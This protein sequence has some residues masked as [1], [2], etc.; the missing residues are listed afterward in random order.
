VPI[1]IRC[2]ADRR[3]SADGSRRLRPALCKC[4]VG[5]AVAAGAA[6]W[7]AAPAAVRAW[8][9]LPRTVRSAYGKVTRGGSGP[10]RRVNELFHG[11]PGRSSQGE[12]LDYGFMRR[13]GR[14]VSSRRS[15]PPNFEFAATDAATQC[16]DVTDKHD[17]NTDNKIRHEYFWKYPI[18]KKNHSKLTLAQIIT[19][20][21][22]KCKNRENLVIFV[23]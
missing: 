7:R 17:K 5:T 9:C 12:D 13:R 15:S 10:A 23:K 16:D 3:R 8:P 1:L 18:P 11:R 6:A 2:V 20:R 14:H 22:W 21:Q 4:G 19:N